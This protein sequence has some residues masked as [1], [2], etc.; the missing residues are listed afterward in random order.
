MLQIESAYTTKQLKIKEAN[1]HHATQDR[2]GQPFRRCKCTNPHLPF[3]S[4]SLDLVGKAQK[5]A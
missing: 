2:I 4:T 3:Q 5:H 1:G